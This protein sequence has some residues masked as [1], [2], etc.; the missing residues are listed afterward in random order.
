M[1]TRTF[2]LPAIVLLAASNANAADLNITV[3]DIRS[4]QGSVGVSVV[5]TAAAWNGEAK[6]VARQKLPIQGKEVV[7]RLTDLPP[8]QYAVSVIHDENDNGKLDANFM[9]MPTEGYGFSNNPV[10]LRKPTFE[11]VQF[12][13]GA[14][15]GA[16]TIRLR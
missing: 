3:T 10:V 5:D 13:L 11:E 9:G 15:G 2:A 4:T 12:Q 16:M 7:F 1:I 14:E 8:G 6:G